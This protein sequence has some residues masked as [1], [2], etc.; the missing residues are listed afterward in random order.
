MVTGNLFGQLQE[1]G[2]APVE[3]PLTASL[4]LRRQMVK[5]ME[6]ELKASATPSSY[7]AFILG[8]RKLGLMT[9]ATLDTNPDHFWSMTWHHQSVEFVFAKHGWPA[10]AEYHKQVMSL[11]CQ[12]F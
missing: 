11:W 7:S 2:M 10:A 12:D 4:F 6:K 5:E 3:G 1:A 8:W 9:R